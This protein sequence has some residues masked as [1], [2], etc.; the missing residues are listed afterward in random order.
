MM[1]LFMLHPVIGMISLAGAFA[2][3]ALALLNEYCTRSLT[4]QAGNA[5]SE[6]YRYAASVLRNSDAIE[7]MGMR[8]NVIGTWDSYHEKSID[9]QSRL[10]SRTNKISSFAKFIRMILQ[11]AVIGAGALLVLKGQLTTGGLIAGMLLMRRA[12]APMDRAIVTWKTFI[13]ARKR[14]FITWNEDW[15][16][17]PNFQHNKP[18]LYPQAI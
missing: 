2:L 18:C 6:S 11:I 3:L 9:L 8:S 7:A 13:S 1:V 5:S 15:N 14:V 17:H 10:N 4:T 12:V 16:L